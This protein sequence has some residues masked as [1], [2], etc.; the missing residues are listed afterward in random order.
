MPSPEDSLVDSPKEE[1]FHKTE[2][3]PECAEPRPRIFTF[4]SSQDK[5]ASRKLARSHVAREIWDQKRRNNEETHAREVPGALVWRLKKKK[6]STPKTAGKKTTRNAL[7]LCPMAV[8]P[9]TAHVNPF[10]DYDLN[11]G[12]DTEE[13]LHHCM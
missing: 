10:P 9:G 3:E 1:H 4:V 7:A 6:K 13:L 12:A 5:C 8:V 2:F 11:Y